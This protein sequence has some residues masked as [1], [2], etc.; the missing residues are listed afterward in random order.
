MDDRLAA[1]TQRH[2]RQGRDGKGQQEDSGCDDAPGRSHALGISGETIALGALALPRHRT[3]L[4]LHAWSEHD[5]R[6]DRIQAARRLVEASRNVVAFSGAGMSTASGIPDFRSPGGVWSRYQPVL[7]QD[8]LASEDA[9]RRYWQAR[10]EMY[11]GFRDARPNAAHLALADLERRGRLEAVVTQNIDGLH[12]EAGSRTVVELHGT[13]RRVICV[14]CRRDHDVAAVY[15][16]LDE[17]RDVPT[18]DDCGGPLKAATI[19]FGQNLDPD[20]LD[21]AFRLARAADL[22]LV[23]GSSLVVQPAAALPV[24]AAEAG[25]TVVIVNR[26]E[27]PLDGLAAVVIHGPVED[28]VPALTA[29]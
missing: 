20:V 6:V 12:Q 27:T 14:A 17:G 16:G 28:V 8:F 18:C 25:A 11:A 13:N 5:D 1:T 26:D 24:A 2:L 9:R 23:L 19:S 7:Y 22:L 3:R 4:T 10:K 29:V 15:A 21:E